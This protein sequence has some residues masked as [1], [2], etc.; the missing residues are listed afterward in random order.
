MN[1][2]CGLANMPGDRGAIQHGHGKLSEHIDHVAHPGELEW[3]RCRRGCW[4]GGIRRIGRWLVG[5]R[6][7]L[8]DLTDTR[9]NCLDIRLALRGFGRCA[10][11][12][13]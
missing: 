4:S 5:L 6:N 2:S 8:L 10:I 1:A 12:A 3:R 7:T 11:H 13:V 9:G